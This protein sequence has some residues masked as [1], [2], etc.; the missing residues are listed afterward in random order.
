MGYL[1]GRRGKVQWAF[2]S[3]SPPR[4]GESHGIASS[5]GFFYSR[6]FREGEELRAG[7]LYPL[8]EASTRR[9]GEVN[10]YR[11]GSLS[12]TKNK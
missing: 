1:R 11:N 2:L 3:L 10:M 8:G 7:W 12:S 5:G 4:I 6:V 9:G